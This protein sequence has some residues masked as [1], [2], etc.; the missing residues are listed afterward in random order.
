MSGAPRVNYREQN[1]SAY[2]PSQ[3]GITVAIVFPSL[4]GPVGKP[5]LAGGRK[6]FLSRFTPRGKVEVGYPTAYFSALT[7]LEATGNLLVVRAAAE[8]ALYAAAT[9]ADTAEPVPAGLQNPDSADLDGKS[10]LISAVDQGAWGND[11]RIAVHGYKEDQDVVLS[12]GSIVSTQVWGAGYPVKFVGSKIPAELSADTTYFIIPESG[13]V[14]VASSLADARASTPTAI[15]IADDPTVNC[16]MVPA[17]QYTK[18][19]GT[20]KISV[21]HKDNLNTPIEEF[22]VSKTQ[23]SKDL[24]GYPLYIEDVLS[25]STYVRAYDN[26]LMSSP[27]VKDVVVPVHLSGGFNGGTVTDGDMVRALN[28]LRNSNEYDIKL[29]IDGGRTTPAFHNALI[30]L[31][32]DRMDCVPILS[33]PLAAQKGDNPAQ[34]IVNFRKYEANFNSSYGTLYAP[35]QKILDEFNGREVWV[36]PDGVVAK[37]IINTAANYEIWFPVGGDTRG[38]VNTLDTFV[39]FSEAEEDLL[40]DNGINPIIFEAGQGI[41]IWGQKTLLSTPSMLDRLNVRLLL[42]TIGP[43]IKR[44]L[45]SFLF[46]FN[47]EATRAMAKAKVDAYMGNVL[48]RRG[49]T[50]FLTICDTTNNTPDDIDNHRLVLD[51]LITPNNSVED[52][53]FTV[54]VVNNSVSFELA[55]QQL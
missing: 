42:V 9:F 30:S 35:H 40:Y 31:C 53:P 51:L 29:I 6:Q 20:M 10:F 26:V 38:V 5:T 18:I 52:I 23:G 24:D 45:K 1:L 39:H 49:V 34:S 50:R 54:G 44:L 19:P 36:S 32:E 16:K 7:V 47:D 22:I 13:K 11:I 33:A 17:V 3:D 21:F 25:G 28:S 12:S 4:R 55:Q 15:S 41:K 46:E 27:Y 37:A 48:A 14:K 8:D 2:T 43:A